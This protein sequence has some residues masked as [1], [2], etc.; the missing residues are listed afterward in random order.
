ML[1]EYS[2][3]LAVIIII[4]FIAT[5]ILRRTRIPP[6]QND[7]DKIISNA[8]HSIR[9][10]TKDYKVYARR[11]LALLGKGVFDQAIEDFNKAAQLQ[12]L[13]ED[14]YQ[15]RGR[16]YLYISEWDKA[17]TDFDH[18]LR[19]AP[20]MIKAYIYRGYGFLIGKK[21]FDAAL[22][23][24]NAAI[25][26]SEDASKKITAFDAYIGDKHLSKRTNEDLASA[27][28]YRGLTFY[29]R[30]QFQ[31]AIEDF[32]AALQL[33]PGYAAVYSGRG[34]TY[35]AMQQFEQAILDFQ[36]A[37]ELQADFEHPII[38]LAITNHALGNIDAAKNFWK[39]LVEKDEHYNDPLWV[40]EHF[41]W[42]QLLADEA[43]KVI[44][45]FNTE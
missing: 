18:T 43:K 25:K 11:G 6:G 30:G 36:H 38:G 3:I 26:L 8:G 37:H 22:N 24:F 13:D 32:E 45:L 33:N 1:S 27:L 9:N 28:Y 44:A 31:S 12:P 14:I 17:I 10:G 20:E 40:Q 2:S 34:E 42:S 5:L 35:F 41:N 15:S 23:D 19:L 7:L 29:I 16:A 39:L 4:Y 21:N